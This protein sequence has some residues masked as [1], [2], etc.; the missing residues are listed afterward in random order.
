MCAPVSS[1]AR[2]HGGRRGAEGPQ[3]AAAGA[4]DAAEHRADPAG[5]SDPGLCAGPLRQVSVHRCGAVRCQASE[6]VIV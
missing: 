2:L 3:L 1:D 5:E 4:A 6:H